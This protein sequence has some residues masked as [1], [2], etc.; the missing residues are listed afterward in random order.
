MVPTPPN[1]IEM[2]ITALTHCFALV[3][4][5]LL[6]HS[7]FHM[8]TDSERHVFFSLSFRSLAP[9]LQQ[10]HAWNVWQHSPQA[11]GDATWCFHHCLVSATGPAGEGGRLQTGVS[12]RFCEWE[13]E[14]NSV[15][16]LPLVALSVNRW[17]SVTSLKSSAVFL[18]FQ[19]EIKQH[20]F[21]CSINWDDLL[22]KR[23]P[24]PF[25]P[26]VVSV[27]YYVVVLSVPNTDSSL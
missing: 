27:P 24:P 5:V 20:S 22:Q 8:S 13:K 10:G 4:S 9:V 6:W 1:K 18:P 23:I 26:K 17:S 7:G 14:V 21:F 2:L 12:G 16:R 15:S 25:T 11:L 3:R 19:N